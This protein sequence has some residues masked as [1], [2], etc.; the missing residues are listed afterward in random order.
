MG[1]A[2]DKMRELEV[3]KLEDMKKRRDDLSRAIANLEQKL[4]GKQ[5]ESTD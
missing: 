2:S 5:E 3:E 1:K 4:Y